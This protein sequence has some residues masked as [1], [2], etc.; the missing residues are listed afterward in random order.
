MS[1]PDME[2][3]RAVRDTCLSSEGVS[4]MASVPLSS[5]M[6]DTFKVLPGKESGEKGVRMIREKSGITFDLYLRVK[7]GEQI[8]ALSWNIQKSV[9]S[10]L[11]NLTDDK[12]KA[13]NI[14]IQGV[15]L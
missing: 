2:L 11:D 14:H 8:P 15:D 9:T 7:Y 5:A 6:N 13:V 4:C 12:I 10:A 3:V 1:D